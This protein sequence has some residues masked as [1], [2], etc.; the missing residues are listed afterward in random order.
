MKRHCGTGQGILVQII[1][2]SMLVIILS[3]W[4]VEAAEVPALPIYLP[5]V[6]ERRERVVG[7]CLEASDL[8]F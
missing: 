5:R 3:R 8:A 1:F 4:K 6:S 7:I 2:S